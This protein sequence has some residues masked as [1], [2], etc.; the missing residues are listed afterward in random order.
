MSLAKDP[1]L[2]TFKEIGLSISRQDLLLLGLWTV[3]TA[4]LQKVKHDIHSTT[5]DIRD[6]SFTRKTIPPLNHPE[7]PAPQRIT[8]LILEI[9]EATQERYSEYLERRLAPLCTRYAATGL[10]HLAGDQE[11]EGH[12]DYHPSANAYINVPSAGGHLH[13]ARTEQARTIEAVRED[14]YEVT[15]EPCTV[16][17]FE[18]S[19]FAHFV[20]SIPASATGFRAAVN[21]SFW[22]PSSVAG[23]QVSH[24]RQTVQ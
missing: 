16:A 13:V 24:P 17:L 7:Q 23:T 22:D 14:G 1:E 20:G 18:G 8:D 10:L 6:F 19:R 9:Y 11:T 21:T 4:K 12:L 3:S 2:V 5:K 15:P